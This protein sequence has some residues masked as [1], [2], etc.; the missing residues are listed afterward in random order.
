MRSFGTRLRDAEKVEGLEQR[1]GGTERSKDLNVHKGPVKVVY[2]HD[3]TKSLAFS[4]SGTEVFVWTLE[5]GTLRRVMNDHTRPVSAICCYQHSQDDFRYDGTATDEEDEVGLARMKRSFDVVKHPPSMVSGG[6][7]SCVFIYSL[8]TFALLH[9]LDNHA[10][11]IS[12][13]DIPLAALNGTREKLPIITVACF[14]G[15]VQLWSLGTGLWL[16]SIALSHGPVTALCVL[17]TPTPG[18][19]TGHSDG[20]IIVSNL[21]TGKM[22]ASLLKTS[23]RTQTQTRLSFSQH[24]APRGIGS[25]AGLV[26]KGGESLG[27]PNAVSTLSCIMAPRPMVLGGYQHPQVYVWDLNVGKTPEAVLLQDMLVKDLRW[28]DPLLAHNSDTEDEDEDDEEDVRGGA[29][30]QPSAS[31]SSQLPMEARDQKPNDEGEREWE[32]E[33][34][35]RHHHHR[36]MQGISEGGVEKKERRNKS[37]R[38][39]GSKRR[40]RS[41]KSHSRSSSE[42]PTR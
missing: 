27:L 38:R 30:V 10:G 4:G 21:R 22:L 33:R 17:P 36:H 8:K 1:G 14:D 11:P 20:S 16:S 34:V 29:K 42:N 13:I 35:R 3:N 28:K 40:S 31:V 15:S 24:L 32:G 39:D 6:E 18:L 5:E 25:G 9:K 41:R 37:S 26:S 2:V 19:I 12:A 7:D 23:A